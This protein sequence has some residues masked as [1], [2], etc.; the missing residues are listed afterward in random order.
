MIMM[1]LFN[2]AG[3]ESFSIRWWSR[4]TAIGCAEVAALSGH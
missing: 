3:S 2:V 1:R 4:E